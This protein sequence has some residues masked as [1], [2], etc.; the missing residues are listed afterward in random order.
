M[1]WLQVTDLESNVHLGLLEGDKVRVDKG[2]L[3]AR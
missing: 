1:K 3:I 2:K